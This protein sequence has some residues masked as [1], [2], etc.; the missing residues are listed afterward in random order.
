[1]TKEEVLAEFAKRGIRIE[2]GGCGC[3]GSP[4]FSVMI[5]GVHVFGE[6]NA[7]MS[8]IEEEKKPY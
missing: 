5:D 6:D 8:N 3:C 7:D 1:M 2:V 4:W